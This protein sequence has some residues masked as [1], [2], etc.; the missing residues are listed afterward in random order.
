MDCKNIGNHGES[1]VI[2]TSSLNFSTPHCMN[3]TYGTLSLVE[4]T[5]SILATPSYSPSLLLDMFY[6]DRDLGPFTEQVNLPCGTYSIELN[7]TCIDNRPRY[8]VQI[9]E[10]LIYPCGYVCSG[11]GNGSNGNESYGYGNGE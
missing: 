6:M 10:I 1:A 5:F 7:G 2:G 8:A 9:T 4:A 3:I 11:N